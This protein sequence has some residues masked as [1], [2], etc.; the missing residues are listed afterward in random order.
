[1]SDGLFLPIWVVSLCESTLLQAHSLYTSE[2]VFLI[3]PI[4]MFEW[5]ATGGDA[6]SASRYAS[7][8]PPV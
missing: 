8:R 7:F 3:T 1:M 2:E 6:T 5:N 4:Y